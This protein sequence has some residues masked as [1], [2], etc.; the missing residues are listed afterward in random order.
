MSLN[1]TPSGERPHIAFFGLTNTG[2]SSLVNALTNQDL[3]I[4]SEQKGTTT[5]PVQKAMEILPLG[6]VVLIDTPGLDDKTALGA[7]RIARS[8][9]VLAHTDLAV[10]VT[11]AGKPLS[12]EEEAFVKKVQDEH[13]PLLRVANKADLLAS[14][15]PDKTIFSVSARTGYQIPQLR[16]KLAQ[17]LN[18]KVQAKPPLCRDLVGPG[19]TCLLVI[20]IDS[21]AP[22]GRLIL[23]QQQVLRDLLDGQAMAFVTSPQT[24]P[25]ALK[26]VRPKLVVCDSQVFEQVAKET[27]QDI[28]LTSFSILMARYKGYLAAAV[29][30]VAAIERLQDGDT[31]LMAEG[32]THH[33]QCE[34]IGTVKIP[35]WLLAH[36][37][38]KLNFVTSSGTSFPEDLHDIALCVL[39][40]GCMLN[41]REMQSRLRL[42][43]AQNVP[44]SNYGIVIAAMRGILQR[45]IAVLPGFGQKQG[46]EHA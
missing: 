3:A 16:E 44:V 4:V 7:Q 27:P 14:C 40:G 15:E 29:E 22:K 33:R 26:Q 11:E 20:P 1:D 10:L 12:D 25:Q 43:L 28:A 8:L 36:T 38:K 34:D 41:A 24:L 45:S 5:D 19:E 42:A 37:G 18:E 21:A 35:R 23:P 39:C 17:L 2:K 32:C 46:E 9:R 30:G 6:P 31:I 13:L